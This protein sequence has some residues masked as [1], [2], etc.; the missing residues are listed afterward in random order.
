MITKAFEILAGLPWNDSLNIAN[1]EMMKI[2]KT[3]FQKWL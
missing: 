1:R 3:N 2:I